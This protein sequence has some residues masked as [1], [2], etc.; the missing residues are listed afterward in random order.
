MNKSRRMVALAAS[1]FAERGWIVLQMDLFGCGDSEGDFGDADWQHWLNDLSF[2][3]GWLQSRCDAPL[4]L[5]SLRAGSLLTADWLSMRNEHVPLLMWQPV[6]NGRQHLTQFLRLKAAN[7]MLAESDAKAAMAFSRAEL[8]AGRSVEIAGYCL[9][10]G[11]A[12]GLEASNLRFPLKYAAPVALLEVSSSER[13]ALSPALASIA[14]KCREAGMTLSEQAVPGAAFWQ[15][16]EIEIAPQLIPAS[17][18]ILKHFV[19]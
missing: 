10:A 4:V 17:V 18:H 7:E 16:Q 15:T 9:T 13:T 1:E 3:W 14:G 11:L 2:A 12:R 8:Q 5:W 6:T 19:S